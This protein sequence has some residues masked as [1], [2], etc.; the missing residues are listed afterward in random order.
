MKIKGGDVGKAPKQCL[1]Q[2][3]GSMV[4]GGSYNL[5]VNYPLRFTSG[6]ITRQYGGEHP[7]SLTCSAHP[8]LGLVE[9][10]GAR[11][12]QLVVWGFLACQSR[13]GIPP[14]VPH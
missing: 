11:S 6:E 5:S 1:P 9:K 7:D 3:K 10:A 14:S 2:S 8:P 4:H 12:T 13:L